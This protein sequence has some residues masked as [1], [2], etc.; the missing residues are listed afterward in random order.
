MKTETTSSLSRCCANA[1]EQRVFEHVFYSTRAR[2]AMSES[3]NRQ[4][5]GTRGNDKQKPASRDRRGDSSADKSKA[6]QQA[7]KDAA[8]AQPPSPGEPAGGE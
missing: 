5:D 4:S 8:L 1:Q 3:A 6:G 7:Q 2:H